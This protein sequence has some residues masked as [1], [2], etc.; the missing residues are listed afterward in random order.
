MTIAR[1][2]ARLKDTDVIITQEAEYDEKEVLRPTGKAW[3]EPTS[4]AGRDHIQFNY[5]D[6]FKH[7][8]YESG[9]DGRETGWVY[10]SNIECRR[11]SQK[12]W[13]GRWRDVEDE[14]CLDFSIEGIDF[15]RNIA[16]SMRDEGLTLDSDVLPI[17]EPK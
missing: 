13:S 15:V 8:H 10:R 16:R 5:I 4:Q 14:D 1:Q 6:A 11:V 2:I 17:N 12:A 9:R 3:F 7:S